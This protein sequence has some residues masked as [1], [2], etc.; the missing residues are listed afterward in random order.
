M[1]IGDAYLAVGGLPEED[2]EHAIKCVLAGK[3]IIQ[4][5]QKRN[6]HQSIKWQVWLGIHSGPITAGS[7]REKEIFIRSVW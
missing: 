6:Q 7:D 2:P 5:L 3:Q 4:Y 1:T